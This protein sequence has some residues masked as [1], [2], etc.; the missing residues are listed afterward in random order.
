METIAQMAKLLHL[1]VKLTT[2]QVAHS[3]EIKIVKVASSKPRSVAASG[4]TVLKY[5]T[6]E[7]LL[8][9]ARTDPL[10][11]RY[12]AHVR[13]C[14]FRL[15]K[16]LLINRL[17]MKLIVMSATLEAEKFRGYF[18]GTPLMRVPGRLH[19]LEIFY[20]KQR[21]RNYLA[22]A[23]QTVVMIYMLY[24]EKGFNTG[25]EAQTYP[26]IQRWNL[27]NTVLILKKLGSITC[28]PIFRLSRVSNYS[29]GTRSLKQADDA[30]QQLSQIMAR[31]NLK[32]CS[33]DFNSGDYYVNIRKAILAR[34]FM[35]MAHLERKGQYLTVKDN[36][37]VQLHPWKS[38][39]HKLEWVVYDEYVLTSRLR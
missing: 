5:L 37:V 34:Y 26:E 6:N 14:A 29:Y 28:G 36:Q 3:V 18:N 8:R 39:D 11:E 22:A 17:D 32:L 7:M 33:S 27:A 9:E 20:S 23:I 24:T 16:E 4:K 15:L 35:Q 31:F 2:Y 10:L 12:K 25:L 19:P 30:R 21:E 13:G 38:L 1:L